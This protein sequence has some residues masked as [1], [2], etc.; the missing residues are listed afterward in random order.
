[1][2]DVIMKRVVS[3]S[4]IK[5]SLGDLGSAGFSRSISWMMLEGSTGTGDG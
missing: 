1:M 5:R 4:V 3:L 2:S